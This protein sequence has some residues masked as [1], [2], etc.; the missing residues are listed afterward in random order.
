MINHMCRFVLDRLVPQRDPA[1][2]E[3]HTHQGRQEVRGG[4]PAAE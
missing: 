1:D 3:W 2:A 4:E